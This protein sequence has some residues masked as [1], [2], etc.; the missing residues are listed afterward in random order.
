ME[1]VATPFE[2]Y[3]G[4]EDAYDCTEDGPD[5]YTDLTIKFKTQEVVAAL[6]EVSDGE[7]LVLSLTG[8]LKEDCGGLPFEGQD[9][10]IILEK[11]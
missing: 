7:V 3:T 11:H 10:V 2:P 4:K 6:G 5:G 1:D 9:V 8:T